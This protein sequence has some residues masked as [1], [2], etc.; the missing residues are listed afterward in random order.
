[1]PDILS[2]LMRNMQDQERGPSPTSLYE[3]G[4]QLGSRL[5]PAAATSPSIYSGLSSMGASSPSIYSG[6]SGATPISGIPSQ[7]AGLGGTLSPMAMG[8]GAG[9]LTESRPIGAGVGALAGLVLG[10]IPGLIMGLGSG[11]IGGSQKTSGPPDYPTYKAFWEGTSA[12]PYEAMG[13]KQPQ[14]EFEQNL[15]ARQ[16]QPLME[17][18]QYNT[19]RDATMQS[20]G[21]M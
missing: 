12:R 20:L 5:Y 6:L 15:A 21:L 1:M 19:W 7:L 8:F 18:K 16:A 14:A 11:L 4:S 3:I 13:Y 9:R 2:N 17:R 10:G